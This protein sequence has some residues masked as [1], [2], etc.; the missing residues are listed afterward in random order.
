MFIYPHWQKHKSG[1]QMFTKKPYAFFSEFKIVI[2]QT[3][4]GKY[5]T[6]AKKKYQF[7][8]C[9][10]NYCQAWCKIFI[11]K[12]VHV[13]ASFK[14]LFF[15]KSNIYNIYH[16]V[17]VTQMHWKRQTFF[18]P[19]FL[20]LFRIQAFTFTTRKHRAE[21]QYRNNFNAY[22]QFSAGHSLW[23][24]WRDHLALIGL[25]PPT[26]FGNLFVLPE[27]ITLSQR[28]QRS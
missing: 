18:T 9:H 15:T 28:V 12:I 1:K 7:A 27:F 5:T 16:K 10:K 20:T 3:S 21:I 13:W 14:N 26:G 22:N 23:D 19:G 6:R 25:S 8:T 11:R 2:R 24:H 17:N 4:L